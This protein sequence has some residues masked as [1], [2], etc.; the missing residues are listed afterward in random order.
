MQAFGLFLHV[1]SVSVWLGASL[2][3]MIF[4]P[5][6]KKM[7][8][9]SW[10]DTWETLAKVQRMLV[11]PMAAVT[12]VTGLLLTMA[13]VKTGFDMGSA[14]WLMVMQGLGLVAA[15]IVIAFVTPM[16]NRMAILA[17][18]SVAKGQADPAAEKVRK[19][20]AVAASISGA[21]MLTALWFGVTK[22]G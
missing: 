4:G 13:L 22:N 1:A 2:T 12:V 19:A 15:I 14:M 16:V 5:A 9:E 20:I 8:L 6:A 17:R 10:A 21:L 11:A 7:P 3:F 18:R